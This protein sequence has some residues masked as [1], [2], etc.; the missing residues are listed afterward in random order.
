MVDF[1]KFMFL[2][3]LAIALFQQVDRVLVGFILGPGTA[4]AYGV[5]TSLGLRLPI[6][7]GQ[8]TEI[9]I[10]YASTKDSL[11]DHQKIYRTFRKMSQY[12]GFLAMGAGV[13]L[14]LLMEEVLALWISPAFAGQY[15]D[16]F[17]VIILAYSL[18]S[19]VRA[20]HQTLTGLGLVRFTAATY[21]GTTIVMLISLSVLA[22]RWGLIGAAIANLCMV[23][24]LAY[25]MRIYRS[26]SA[27][28]AWRHMAQ[29]LG[30]P[31]LSCLVAF[32]VSQLGV[33]WP[34]RLILLALL[35][36]ALLIRLYQDKMLRANIN[37]YFKQLVYRDSS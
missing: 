10:P 16:V 17:R 37:S 4:G 22:S 2:E 1:S 30:M 21:L 27:G 12:I 29:D 23:L 25:N 35:W 3:S 8:A 15:S 5:G 20:G 33:A 24:L 26:L 18:L 14:I 19:L 36:S 7:T 31:V 11:G 6:I 32:G 34:L 9:M 13:F 28:N